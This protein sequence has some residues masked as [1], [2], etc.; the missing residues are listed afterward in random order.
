MRSHSFSVK[1]ILVLH[2]LTRSF[3]AGE[4]RFETYGGGWWPF[5]AKQIIFLHPTLRRLTIHQAQFPSRHFAKFS[6]L[7]SYK[8]VTALEE[9]SLEN[10]D[11]SLDALAT[12]LNVPRALK[13]LSLKTDFEQHFHN[14]LDGNV[15][16]LFDALSSQMYGYLI[17]PLLYL[18]TDH[19]I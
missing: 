13:Q 7:T 1:R 6:T 5:E 9:L 15:N 14:Y 8:N 16:Q 19:W 4:L 11:P 10:C 17:S 2:E 12:L 18:W 3:N